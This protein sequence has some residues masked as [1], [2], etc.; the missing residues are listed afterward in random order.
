MKAFSHQT[1]AEDETFQMA[2]GSLRR[3][4]TAD[5]LSPSTTST[6]RST[7]QS[8]EGESSSNTEGSEEPAPPSTRPRTATVGAR[9]RR[10]GAAKRD[11][12]E[13]L[14]AFSVRNRLLKSLSLHAGCNTAALSSASSRWK[15]N[16]II[17]ELGPLLPDRLDS[18]LRVGPLGPG[19]EAGPG[20]CKLES[21]SRALNRAISGGDPVQLFRT[22]HFPPR[23]SL[24]YLFYSEVM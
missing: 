14:L 15:E 24:S 5:Q 22:Q 23:R 7:T 9:R 11:A 19:L 8:G 18:K 12:G 13:W 4:V 2:F 20:E 10:G 1:S 21:S 6:E 17:G 3:T 16:R